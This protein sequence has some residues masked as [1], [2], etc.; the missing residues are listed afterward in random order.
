MT[1]LIGSLEEKPSRFVLFALW[2]VALGLLLLRP[3][4]AE[5]EPPTLSKSTRI[6]G[7]VVEIDSKVLGERRQIY[8]RTPE[9]YPT[10]GR[11]YPVLYV[12]DAEWHFDLATANVE[13][14]SEC[15]AS[16]L[17]IPEMIVVGII[18]IDR[19][20][21][22]TPTVRTEYEG[23]EF[24]T[25]GGAA[26]FLE[27]LE[28]ELI[29]AIDNTYR[30]APYRVLSGWSFGGLF[31]FF[32]YMNAPE[33]FNAFLGISP[34]LWW[35][36]STLL[37]Q[38]SEK[39]RA[40]PTKLIATIG[41]A[42]EG[43]WT[44]TAT[45]KLAQQLNDQPVGGLDFRLL[46]IP[47]VGHN[48]SVPHGFNEGLKAVFADWLPPS[49]VVEQGLVPIELYYQELSTGYGYSVA[50]PQPI[51]YGLAVGHYAEDEFDEATLL[52]ER[53]VRQYPSDSYSQYLLGRIAFKKKDFAKADRLY[54]AAVRTERGQETPDPLSLRNFAAAIEELDQ[55]ANDDS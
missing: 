31:T 38:Y 36:E 32:A 30:T 18:N 5:A 35:D 54:A 42:E 21:D 55:V 46:E 48:L 33:V 29:P 15:S 1:A 9:S 20:K 17:L 27:F 13:Y 16:D 28:V 37:E 11:S 12:L 14:L 2:T 6:L 50:V 7:E 43:G 39:K 22:F 24:P 40:R 4:V 53:L 34:S 49:E 51:L 47:G 52:F 26:Q 45:T 23:M 44:H 3:P 8:I 19:D 25:S 10:G 41:T